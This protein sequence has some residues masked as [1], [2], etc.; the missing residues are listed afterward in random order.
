MYVSSVAPYSDCRQLQDMSSVES[1]MREAADPR[2][3]AQQRAEVL[4]AVAAAQVRLLQL[5]ADYAAIFDQTTTVEQTSTVER[6]SACTG[7]KQSSEMCSKPLARLAKTIR[8]ASAVF[9][10]AP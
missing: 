8:Q 5:E 4:R 6:T 10:T 2:L 9:S 1:M 3:T 7:P